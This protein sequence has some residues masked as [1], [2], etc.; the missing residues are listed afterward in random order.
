M[1]KLFF[2]A[3]GMFTMGCDNFIVVC[4]LPGISASLGA[5]PLATSQGVTAFGAAYAVSAPLFALLLA[6]KPTRLVLVAALS[7]FLVGNLITILAPDLAAYLFGRAISGMGAGLYSPIA[8][9]TGSQLVDPSSRGRALGL[10]WG[11]NNAGSVIGGPLGLWLSGLWSWKAGIGLI[12]GI[13]LLA[14]AG[15]AALQPRLK[16]NA[17]PSL[18]ERVLMLGDARVLSVICITFATA[19]ASLGL[20]TFVAPIS[21]GAA[22]PVGQAVWVWSLG[23]L[24]GS[25]GIG[26]LVDY[27]GKPRLVMAGV[28]CVLTAAVFCIPLLR[29][30]PYL[31]LAPFLLWGMAG[32]ATVNP[33]LH[34]LFSLQPEQSATLA[35]LNGSAVSLGGVLGSSAGALVLSLG[36]TAQSLPF[37]AVSVLVLALVF[38]LAMIRTLPEAQACR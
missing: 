16:V 20:F 30:V 12:M 19:A 8:V 4:L 29:S 25:Y 18:K 7:I 36:L 38:Q 31:S 17:I 34:T 10:L 35:A 15:I 24:L 11:S 6:K 23:G 3:A 14:L 2:L 28:I 27:S 26:H 21:E 5:S 32:W 33:Q 37:A 1:R 9:A 22:S 13:A